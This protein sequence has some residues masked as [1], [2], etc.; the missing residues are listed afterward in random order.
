MCCCVIVNQDDVMS[1][2]TMSHCD[3]SWSNSFAP[4]SATADVMHISIGE[5]IALQSE[6][7]GSLDG[8]EV[9]TRVSRHGTLL[10]L[11]IVSP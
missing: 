5:Y 9:F 6:A 2:M 4:A 8:D 1:S 11:V 10:C 3:S 7:L